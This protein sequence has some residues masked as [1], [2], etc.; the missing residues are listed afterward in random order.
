V[1]VKVDAYPEHD[2]SGRISRVSPVVDPAT[3]STLIE[4]KLDNAAGKL[5]SGMF[6]EVTLITGSRARVLAVPK[7]ALVDGGGQGA[8]VP[9]GQASAFSGRGSGPAVFVVENGKAVRRDVEL[10]LQG[11]QSFEVRKGVRAGDKVVVF[12]LYGLKDNSPVDVLSELPS[13]EKDAE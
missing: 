7:D 8:A 1:R 9:E 11:D 10:G 3:R 12:G 5:R 2:F 4:A 6:G 13:D